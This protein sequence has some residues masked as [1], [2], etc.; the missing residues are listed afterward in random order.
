MTTFHI[1]VLPGDYIGPE[2]VGEAVRVLEAAGRRFGHEFRF[3]EALAGGA[4]FDAF[5]E[6]LPASTLATCEQADAILKGPFGGPR[7]EINH[8]K[9]QG[10]EQNAILP[11][12]KHFDLYLNLRPISV[13]DALLP[14]SP[15]K[16]EHVRGTDMLICRELTS[17]LY[18]GPRGEREVPG[19][20]ERPERE[21]FDTELYREHEIERI[22]RDGFRLAAGRRRKLTL[23]AKS[24]VMKSGLFWR[25]VAEEVAR[26]FPDVA[27]D[28]MHV[29]AASMELI[30]NPRQFDV[31]VTSNMFGDILSDEAA[32]LLRSL[33][34]GP[35]ASLNEKGFGLYEP[36]H[37]SAPDIA[38]QGKA[39]PIA[40]I[41]SAAMMLR[42]SFNLPDA[43]SAVERAV[44][45][46]L[47]EGARTPDLISAGG[48]LVTTQEMGRRIAQAVEAS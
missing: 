9:W 42:L 4:A 25:E 29:D 32:A 44:E 28:Y 21:V 47:A 15:L 20:Y 3:S 34:M 7:T 48:E 27:M 14:L 17:G 19:P 35:S 38:G 1:A 31:I 6:H 12:R 16:E 10:V 40:T 37:G 26:A 23:I 2:V 8:P 46:V 5:G 39:N 45:K 33:G 13:P 43:S 11:L 41:L 24:N 30:I 22:V 36:I 18:F